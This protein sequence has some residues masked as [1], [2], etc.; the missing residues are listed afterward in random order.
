MRAEG[1]GV[2]IQMPLGKDCSQQSTSVHIVEDAKK[3]FR[4][5]MQALKMH[6][7]FSGVRL[8][9]QKFTAQPH[10]VVAIAPVHW[11]QFLRC[12]LCLLN[13]ASPLH[14]KKRA[15]TKNLGWKARKH[16]AAGVRAPSTFR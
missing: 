10:W 3:N 7:F 1:C 11:G 15:L 5:A 9:T 16:R 12:V 14:T 6:N 4:I 13:W 8:C 2:I